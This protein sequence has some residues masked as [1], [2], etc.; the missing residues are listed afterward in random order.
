MHHARSDYEGIVKLARDH[1]RLTK[2]CQNK[3]PDVPD[4]VS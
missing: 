1:A 2:A 4:G 3:V